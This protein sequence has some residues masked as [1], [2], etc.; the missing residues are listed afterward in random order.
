MV[1]VVVV[2]KLVALELVAVVVTLPHLQPK[3]LGLK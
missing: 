2:L 3:G 1:V